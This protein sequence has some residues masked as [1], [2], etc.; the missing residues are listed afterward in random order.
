MVLPSL[1]VE[2]SISSL[3]ARQQ[4]L[5]AKRDDLARRLQNEKRAPRQASGAAAV[6]VSTPK[7]RQLLIQSSPVN[8]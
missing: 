4:E 5:R 2:R 6:G 1:Q 8:T 7:S 3:L